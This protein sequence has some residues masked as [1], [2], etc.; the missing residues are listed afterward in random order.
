MNTS[1]NGFT[2][3]EIIFIV[4][5]LAGASTLFFFQKNSLETAARDDIRKTAVNAMHYGLEEVYFEKNGYYPR[6]L[7]ADILPSVDPA[8]FTD[9]RGVAIGQSTSE[10]RY[11]PVA[12]N[13]EECARYTLRAMLE[14][15]DDYVKTSRSQ[16]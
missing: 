9:P 5:L 14:N 3:I 16:D 1:T 15:E 12:C 8:L 4:V 2:V 10:Y 13:G 7:N 6:A 11:E